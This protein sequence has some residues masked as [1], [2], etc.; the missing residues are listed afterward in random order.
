MDAGLGCARSIEMLARDNERRRRSRT[1]GLQ[2]GK[3]DGDVSEEDQQVRGNFSLVQQQSRSL[4]EHPD[5]DVEPQRI[6]R[7]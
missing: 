6:K 2:G 1:V 3:K 7:C 5:L 4:G